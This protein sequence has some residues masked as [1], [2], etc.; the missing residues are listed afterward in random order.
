VPQSS[1]SGSSLSI[2]LLPCLSLIGR[3]FLLWSTLLQQLS[4]AVLASAAL[5]PPQQ[6]QI[7]A[8]LLAGEFM[9]VQDSLNQQQPAAM[10]YMWVMHRLLWIVRSAW[11]PQAEAASVVISKWL[12][13]CDTPTELAA[14][15]Y[16]ATA[17]APAVLQAQLDGLSAGT[18]QLQGYVLFDFAAPLTA[19]RNQKGMQLLAAVQQQLQAV[20]Q[21]LTAFAIPHACN[22]P[23]CSN[24]SGPSEAQLVGG[25]SSICAGCVTA[26]YCGKACQKQHWKQHQPVCKALAAAASSSG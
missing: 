20:R 4:A 5:P 8:Q 18:E 23:A 11:Q 17:A 24:V 22:N 26:R 14:L 21:S 2:T 25:K 15:G 1:S 13:M 6:A 7:A 10:A 16:A 9:H 3:S 19:A 12:H